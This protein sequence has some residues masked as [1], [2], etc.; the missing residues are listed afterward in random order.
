M[1]ARRWRVHCLGKMRLPASLLCLRSARAP[2]LA[3][4]AA[5][6]LTT[7]CPSSALQG[8]ATSPRIEGAIPAVNVPDERFAESLHRVL[9]DGTPSS[10]RLGLLAGVVRRQ[11]AHAAQRFATGHDARGTTSVI[12]GLY[13]VR[14]GEGRKEMLDASGDRALAGAIARLSPRGDEGRSFALMKMRAAT[15]DPASPARLEI[16]QHLSALEQW[17]S[18][19]RSGS[20]MR[21]LGA[22]E[23]AKVAQALLDPSEAAIEAAAAAIDAWIS[24]AIV[25][26]NEFR[27]SGK[28]PERE[29]AIEAARALESGGAT[30]A[31]LFLR[32]GD[33]AGARKHIDD[34]SA[35]RVILPALYARIRDAEVSDTNQARSFLALASAFA[36]HQ[37]PEES[38]PET[39]IEDEVL[40]AGLWGSTLEAYR[41]DPTN[42]DASMLLARSLVRFG[43]PEAAPLLLGE[44]LATQKSAATVGA[45]LVLVL[46]AISESAEIDD[47]DAA[48]RTFK[49]AGSILAEADRAELRGKLDPSPARVRFIMSS[50]AIRAGNL[51]EAR[52]LLRTAAQA[53]PSASGF[54][55]LALVER[56]AGDPRAA[57]AAV[58]QA[59]RAPDARVSLL[60]VAEA[61]LTAFE[62]L[63][64]TKA[65]PEL[66]KGSLD[67]ALAVALA[68]RQKGNN[69][70][71]T[72]RAERLL[73]RILEGYGDTK[74]AT[75]AFERALQAAAADR[76]TLGAAM[77]D[78]I[79][80]ALVRRDLIAARGALKRGLDANVNDDDLVYGGLWVSLLERELRAPPD[81]TVERALRGGSKTAWTAKLTAWASGKLSDGDLN[82]A[83]QSATQRVEAAFYTAM[84]RKAAGDPAAEQRLRAVAEAPVVDLLEVQLARELLAPHVR[85]DLPGGIK[86]P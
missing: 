64:D 74:G 30:M 60:D 8:G 76:P 5:S 11:L 35:K 23:R 50:I 7:G 75:R 69:P 79:G 18:D 40:A 3:A 25:Y 49:A 17:M 53:E 24:Q 72:A 10:D 15:L 84:A 27:Q 83:A 47:L 29:D 66:S 19:T 6:L 59:L 78:A 4:I 57:L 62:L 28:R 37:D 86:L 46:T 38:D 21:R 34:T 51:A 82:T 56:Q 77:L 22:E 73:G 33:A 42:F 16:D 13:L 45:A 61:H 26:N 65:S 48:A 43:M 81:G 36:H 71:A 58:E 12:G 44:A 63:R 39:D 80:R 2:L 41:R 31:A 9:R 70:A 68:A 1:H 52:S 54:T 67:A 14:V 32:Y 85:A 55:T 20:A